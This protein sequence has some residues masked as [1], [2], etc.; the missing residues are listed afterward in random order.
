MKRKEQEFASLSDIS[1]PAFGYELIR[2][3]LL[4]EILGQDKPDIIYWAGKRL[5]RKYPL[6]SIEEIYEFFA[7]A[8]WG[9]LHLTKENRRNMTFALTGD[10]IHHRLYAKTN[11]CFRL[12]AGF[13]AEQIQNQ[14]KVYAE[15]ME[16]IDKK[17]S[18]I[19]FHVKWEK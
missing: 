11:S 17:K 3:D 9:S 18:T 14:K 7:N 2:E 4:D 10:L 5:A 12:E 8:G 19:Y 13:L 6:F 1:I 15:C 16:E